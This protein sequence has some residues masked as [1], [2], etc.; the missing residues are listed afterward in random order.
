MLAF[1]TAILRQ[2]ALT[3]VDKK[4]KERKGKQGTQENLGILLGV[5]NSQISD[6]RLGKKDIPIPVVLKLKDLLNENEFLCFVAAVLANNKETSLNLCDIFPNIE[7]ASKEVYEDRN[8]Y[9]ISSK[10]VS[11]WA[12]F[13]FFLSL[14][15]SDFDNKSATVH[16]SIE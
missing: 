9:Q 6:Y 12:F 4:G 8:T 16:G 5:S 1:D 7:T 11:D 13:I 2:S 14:V 10:V 15:I 3:G